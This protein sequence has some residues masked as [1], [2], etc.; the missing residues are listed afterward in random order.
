MRCDYYKSW[1][2]D[3]A[4]VADK[5]S[6]QKRKD[7]VDMPFHKPMKFHQPYKQT[8]RKVPVPRYPK[9]YDTWEE[10]DADWAFRDFED[11]VGKTE[12]DIEDRMW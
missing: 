2:D 6:Y 12:Y 4:A 9:P 11:V 5:A 1:V 3:T 10:K 8:E 7:N